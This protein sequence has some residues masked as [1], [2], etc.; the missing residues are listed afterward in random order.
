MVGSGQST[1]EER[2]HEQF[3]V[4]TEE[5][6]KEDEAGGSS[7]PTKEEDVP[8]MEPAESMIPNPLSPPEALKRVYSL[9]VEV[10]LLRDR[11]INQAEQLQRQD[12]RLQLLE[13]E[14]LHHRTSTPRS[15]S[16]MP[17]SLI[18]T[19]NL[20]GMAS[21]FPLAPFSNTDFAHDIDYA[22][23][24]PNAPNAQGIA[25]APQHGFEKVDPHVRS[26]IDDSGY[27]GSYG[28]GSAPVD[29][30]FTG[31]FNA[32]QWDRNLLELSSLLKKDVQE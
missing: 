26:I 27:G 5:E 8:P 12:E 11:N 20:F 13:K 25:H 16:K 23:D 9:E 10:K 15:S 30:P 31:Y 6:E 32:E 19:T 7:E 18:M 17:E 2:S 1:T 21:D 14:L 24:M 22:A 4:R 28:L 29:E 3:D